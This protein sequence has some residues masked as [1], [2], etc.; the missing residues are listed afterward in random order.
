M[1][2]IKNFKLLRNQTA[3]TSR[4][5]AVSALEGLTLANEEG[6][7]VLARYTENSTPGSVLGIVNLDGSVTVLDLSGEIQDAIQSLDS[8]LTL[9]GTAAQD[10]H[11]TQVAIVDGM[12]NPTTSSGSNIDIAHLVDLV[13][14]NDAN[15]ILA[16]TDTIHGALTKIE[17]AILGMDKAAN[18]ETGKVLTTVTQVD[19]RIT[20]E[21]KANVIDLALTGYSKEAASTGAI[22][23]SDDIQTALS[24]LE[25]AIA[26]TT[27]SSA[28]QTVVIDDSG[29]TTDLSVN[30][31]GTTIVKGNDGVLSADLELVQLTS[32]EVTALS[33]VNVK[34]A[35]KLI[36]STDS[37]RTAIGGV[38]KIYKD[39]SLQEVYLGASTDTINAQTGVI[40][41]NTVTD[42]QSLNFAYQLADGTYSLVKID[43]SK[44]LTESEFGDGLIVSGAGVVSVNAGDGL[45]FDSSDP[46]K[47]QVKVGDGLEIDSTSKAV[48]LKIDS[49][50][51]AVTTGASTTTPVLSASSSGIK[52][53]GIQDAINYAVGE[54]DAEAVKSGTVNGVA[55]TGTVTN[56]NLDLTVAGNNVP[57]T[58]YQALTPTGNAQETVTIAATDTTNQAFAKVEKAINV[59]EAVV[60]AALNDLDSTKVDVISVNGVQSKTPATGDVVA[61]VTIDGGDVDLTGYTKPAS[62]SAIAATDSVNDAIG[63]LERRL[64]D[65][66]DD[67]VQSVT[68]VAPISVDNTDTNN[69]VVS[70]DIA[71]SNGTSVAG[72]ALTQPISVNANDELTFAEYLDAG[73]YAV[74]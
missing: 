54:L 65:A 5:A 35:Y 28:D 43:V 42:P 40:T 72:A 29:A 37:N 55:G 14:S 26:D 74:S 48:E 13:P 67:G 45:E 22:S 50:S 15:A 71:A 68:G 31:D 41:K 58:G 63:K 57:L 1:A 51:E 12:L 3:L 56:N 21:T 39:S 7:L 66:I 11:F 10:A 38:V 52:V 32:A 17:A 19:G 2:N 18:A 16:T 33:D 62:G 59:N 27:V 34:D 70:L 73:Y 46:K 53:D 47:V 9:S 36:Y 4:A 6:T 24:K 23:G 69:P 61:S 60:A 44:F 20:E 64:D 8:T 49:S 25:N 30:I